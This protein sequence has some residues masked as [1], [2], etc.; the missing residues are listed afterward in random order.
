MTAR[1]AAALA[2]SWTSDPRWAGIE[3]A[4]SADD[5]LRLSGSIRIRH[6]LAER[7]A[8]R[9]WRLLHEED[10]VAALGALT[11]NQAIQQV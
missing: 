9:L 11:G 5:V 1:N 7:G 6:T 4:Y 8:D 2:S 10:Y 3:R